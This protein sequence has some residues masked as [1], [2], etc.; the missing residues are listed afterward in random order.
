MSESLERWNYQVLMLVQALIGAIS[1]N[2]RM[3]TISLEGGEWVTRFYLEKYDEEDID[4]IEEVMC[5]YAAYQDGGLKSRYEV[6]VGNGGLPGYSEVGRVVYRRRESFG[7]S[8][9]N[10]KKW[11]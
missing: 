1:H 11:D 4:E 10:S 8:E 6:L 5:Q 2:F 9:G 7:S 3:V